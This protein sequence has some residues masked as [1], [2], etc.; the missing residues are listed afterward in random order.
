MVCFLVH[1][2]DFLLKEKKRAD[3]SLRNLENHKINRYW[4][5]WTYVK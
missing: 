5:R 2:L 4:D 3:Q 1:V